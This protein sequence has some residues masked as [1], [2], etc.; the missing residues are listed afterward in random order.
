MAESAVLVLQSYFY[1]DNGI[2]IRQLSGFLSFFISAVESTERYISCRQICFNTTQGPGSTP[3]Y[4]FGN[5]DNWNYHCL[6]ANTI[7]KRP[8]YWLY[9]EWFDQYWNGKGNTGTF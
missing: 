7:C 1:P 8:A 9:P 4:G 5:A 6:P 3:I 2:A